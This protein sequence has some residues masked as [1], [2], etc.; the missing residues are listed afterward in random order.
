MIIGLIGQI[1]KVV[2]GALAYAEQSITAHQ[3]GT[4]TVNALLSGTGNQIDLI[5]VGG[6]TY[7]LGSQGASACMPVVL[8]TDAR[9]RSIT[10]TPTISAVA[11]GS[12]G[13]YTS[14]AVLV[15]A[16]STFAIQADVTSAGTTSLRVSYLCSL[17]G[18]TYYSPD[19]GGEIITLAS[20]GYTA[21][22]PHTCKHIK[23]YAENLALASVT[24]TI[25]FGRQVM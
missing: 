12:G 7:Q 13:T 1:Q 3:G 9:F 21:F 17:D 22:A 23:L 5:R 10:V 20:S 4:W 8:A 6:T 24:S 15:E 2:S 19:G 18:T 16:G 25:H 14:A 11:L